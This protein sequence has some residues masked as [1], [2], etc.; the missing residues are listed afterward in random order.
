MIGPWISFGVSMAGIIAIV[1]IIEIALARHVRKV[2]RRRTD[3]Q[4]RDVEGL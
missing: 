4:F 1:T 3:Q 2:E